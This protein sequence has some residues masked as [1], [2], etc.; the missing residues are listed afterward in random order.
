MINLNVESFQSSHTDEDYA[1]SSAI[2]GGGMAL[3]CLIARPIHLAEKG[4]ILSVSFRS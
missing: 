1:T 4:V 2:I 3:Y